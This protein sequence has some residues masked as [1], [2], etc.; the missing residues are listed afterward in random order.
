MLCFDWTETTTCPSYLPSLPFASRGRSLNSRNEKK[1]PLGEADTRQKRQLAHHFCL[2]PPSP[3]EAGPF[4]PRNENKGPLDEADMLEKRQSTQHFCW[5]VH[6]LQR[7]V[8]KL[9]K[10]EKWTPGRGWYARDTTIYPTFR[11]GP[12]FASRGRF[13]NW[14]NENKGPLDEADMLEKRQSTHHFCWSVHRL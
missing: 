8:L 6:R 7:P 5:S 12:P 9:K 3:P 2:V 1:E 10:W 14:R 11:P 4:N 13:L